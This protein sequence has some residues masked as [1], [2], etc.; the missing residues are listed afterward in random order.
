MGGSA[1]SNGEAHA[2]SQ[3]PF[4]LGASLLTNLCILK[5]SICYIIHNF[6]F[7]YNHYIPTFS[8]VDLGMILRTN[9]NVSQ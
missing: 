7:E 8:L 1:I 6:M 3:H 5:C 9:F 2:N 4:F